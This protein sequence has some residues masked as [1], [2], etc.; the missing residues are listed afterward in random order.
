MRAWMLLWVS[1]C[2]SAW[3]GTAWAQGVN[4]PSGLGP[5]MVFPIRPR[6]EP[7]PSTAVPNTSHTRPQRTIRL[8]PTYAY[9][10][11]RARPHR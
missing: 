11:Y 9:P 6:S 8:Q 4:D 10:V 2:I 7:P 5:T 3:A 1:V